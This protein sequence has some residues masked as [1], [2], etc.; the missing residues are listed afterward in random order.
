ML[1]K[2]LPQLVLPTPLPVGHLC[3][4]RRGEHQGNTVHV[5]ARV[6][7]LGDAWRGGSSRGSRGGE[8]TDAVFSGL[9]FNSNTSSLHRTTAAQQPQHR[10]QIFAALWT[11]LS[12]FISSP[13]GCSKCSVQQMYALKICGHLNTSNLYNVQGWGYDFHNCVI[14]DISS[15]E[16]VCKI[17]GLVLCPPVAVMC[18]QLPRQPVQWPG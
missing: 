18:P 4:F 7:R 14:H 12:T 1:A 16:S 10:L 15:C 2:Y 3:W 5:T 9:Y 13:L 17:L 6:S 8:A 11:E